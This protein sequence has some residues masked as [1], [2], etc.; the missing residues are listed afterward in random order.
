MQSAYVTYAV[1][2]IDSVCSNHLPGTAVCHFL[3]LTVFCFKNIT[4][5]LVIHEDL[6]RSTG[7]GSNM[8]QTHKCECFLVPLSGSVSVWTIVVTVSQLQKSCCCVN[9]SQLLPRCTTKCV[10]T[11]CW[12]SQERPKLICHHT[13]IGISCE[14]V[15][16]ALNQ[17]WV[18]PYIYSTCMWISHT[19][20]LWWWSFHASN[21]PCFV[22]NIT[23]WFVWFLW[24]LCFGGAACAYYDSLGAVYIYMNEPQSVSITL[25]HQWQGPKC[26]SVVPLLR[27]DAAGC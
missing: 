24:L 14:T 7:S 16:F 10:S 23:G 19:R 22:Q 9:R 21:R 13:L 18:T 27:N 5:C 3:E 26:Q 20:L 6:T 15:T 2:F 11:F 1:N 4:P 8:F 25:L 17:S 12:I